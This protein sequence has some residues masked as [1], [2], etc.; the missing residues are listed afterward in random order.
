MHLFEERLFPVLLLLKWYLR[1]SKTPEVSI[2]C[3]VGSTVQKN[4]TNSGSGINPHHKAKLMLISTSCCQLGIALLYR[5]FCTMLW[6]TLH[7]RRVYQFK[8]YHLSRS[9]YL[10]AI[11]RHHTPLQPTL[12][13]TILRKNSNSSCT[14]NIDKSDSASAPGIYLKKKKQITVCTGKKSYSMKSK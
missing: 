13:L 7:P 10:H 2:L 8:S 14:V 1:D 9:S 5:H 11:Y 6:S 12:L 4:L 3:I